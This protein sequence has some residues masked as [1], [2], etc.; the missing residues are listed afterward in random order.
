MARVLSSSTAR[1]G[2]VLRMR[3]GM[4]MTTDH[5]LGGGRPAVL[6]NARADPPDRGQ[7]VTQAQASHPIPPAARLPGAL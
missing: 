5:T 2:R 6:G 1:E 7:G 3:F 4:G